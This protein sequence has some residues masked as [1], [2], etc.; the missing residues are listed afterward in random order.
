MSCGTHDKLQLR[1]QLQMQF[2]IAMAI[3]AAQNATHFQHA[4]NEI[5]PIWV[6]FFAYP[7]PTAHTQPTI[8]IEYLRAPK[9]LPSKILFQIEIRWE[10]VSK[11]KHQTADR[12]YINRATEKANFFA[13]K[14]KQ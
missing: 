13:Q 9:P 5:S 12:T 2:E 6:A 4:T 8:Q 3:A 11:P 1:V 10:I 14:T 7:I